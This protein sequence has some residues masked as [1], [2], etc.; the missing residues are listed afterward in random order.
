M[1]IDK[2]GIRDEDKRRAQRILNQLRIGQRVFGNPAEG[3]K[4]T[5]K[6]LD[7]KVK[8]PNNNPL[9][10]Q[11][12]DNDI[13]TEIARV[14]AG[15]EGEESLARYIEKMIKLDEGLDG[16]IA[17]ASLSTEVGTLNSKGY[18]PDTDFLLVYGRNIL[19]LDAKNIRTHPENP[20]FLAKGSLRNMNSVL[21]EDIQPSTMFWKTHFENH[22]IPIDSIDGY[23]VIYNK[24]GATILKNAE[25]YQ[26]DSK[27]IHISDLNQTLHDWI[28][29]KDG[30]V[31]L[32]LLTF[33]SKAQI[34]KP[35]SNMDL[36]EA[37]RRFK[38]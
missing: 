3:L 38:L 17:F 4:I 23:M 13:K 28:Q 29:G 19:V 36:S 25:W 20:V 34:R 30:T 5:L 14:K 18:I 2:S 7:K 27:P 11:L 33:L 24:I 1:I 37:F 32:S 21:V 8:Q 9:E 26:S 16:L 31:S 6:E 12:Q 35:K 15:I 22:G 10:F